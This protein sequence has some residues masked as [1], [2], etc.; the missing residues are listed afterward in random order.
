MFLGVTKN[1]KGR[2]NKNFKYFMFN[3]LKV[4]LKMSSIFNIV[5]FK[6]KSPVKYIVLDLYL[7]LN[8]L[9]VVPNDLV[10]PNYII[11]GFLL[12]FIISNIF[13]ITPSSP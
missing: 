6:V 9:V 2:L 7:I 12:G 1:L 11:N 10:S 4:I 8:D 5:D 13:K 3:L